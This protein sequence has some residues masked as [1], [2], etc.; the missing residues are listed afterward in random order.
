MPYSLSGRC[1]LLN[2]KLN[3]ARPILKP[4]PVG[5]MRTHCHSRPATRGNLDITTEMYVSR[6]TL[7]KWH[8]STVDGSDISQTAGSNTTQYYLF[9]HSSREIGTSFSIGPCTYW[10]HSLSLSIGILGLFLPRACTLLARR[11]NIRLLGKT[12]IH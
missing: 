5:Q 8:A 4:A 7:S 9:H 3:S 1:S 2:R 10:K 12:T 6:S 11:R